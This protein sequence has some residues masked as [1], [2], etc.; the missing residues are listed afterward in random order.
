MEMH[1][2][3]NP[4]DVFNTLADMTRPEAKKVVTV[5]PLYVIA[6]EIRK[7][8][9]TKISPYAKPYL[10]A[11]TTMSTMEEGYI[12]DSGYEIIAKF[13]NSASGWRGETARKVKKELKKIAGIK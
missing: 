3:K 13:L 10:S 6:L 8:W 5:R 2:A 12:M 11:M 7:D 9:G 1:E 4:T